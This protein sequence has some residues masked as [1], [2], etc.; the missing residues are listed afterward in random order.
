MMDA[1]DAGRVEPPTDMHNVS[2]WDDY[3]KSRMMEVEER[4]A[5]DQRA[6][7][8]ALPALLE[9]R[10]ARTVL[11]VGNGL[12]EEPAALALCGFD[13]VALDLSPVVATY[14]RLSLSEHGHPLRR[15]PGFQLGDDGVV[16]FGAPGPI[17]PTLCP[18]IHQPA[19]LAPQGGGSL[20]FVTGDLSSKLVSPGPFDAVIERRTL[21]HFRESD[22]VAGLERLAARL[23]AR[24]TLVS[25]E[26]RVGKGPDFVNPH[27]AEAW[28]IEHGFSR[29]DARR[30][31]ENDAA[32]R[33]AYLMNTFG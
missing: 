22:Q 30:P 18:S 1:S 3:W 32:P 28:L 21:Q 20:R 6:S 2:G 8:P 16:R 24:G 19:E 33:L 26:H 11:C 27:F 31:E 23:A 13:V 4:Q 29:Y 12:S 25:Q 7:D 9:R 15:V 5:A 14:S 10:G 17:D